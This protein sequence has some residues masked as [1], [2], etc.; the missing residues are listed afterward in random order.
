MISR[1][2]LIVTLLLA[3]V[4][5]VNLQ[6]AEFTGRFSMLGSTA[7]ATRGDIGYPN[8]DR[9]LTADQQSLRVMLDE[10]K[11]NSAW[12]V[13]VKMARQHLSNIPF[14][15]EHSSDLFRYNTLSTHWL[16]ESNSNNATRI[17]YEVD[18]AH[19]KHNLKNMTF[20]L[21][22]QP[23]DWGSARLWQP[24]NVFG[25][26]S[27]TD[28]DTDYKP[29]IDAARLDWF[30]SDFSAL[31]AVY[32]FSSSDN[33]AIE[34]NTNSALHYRSKIGMQSEYALLA[35]NIIDYQ[36]FGASFESAWAGLGW[37]V[38]AARYKETNT[39]KNSFFWV[40]GVD[41]QFKNGAIMTAEWYENDR[42]AS[43]VTSLINTNTQSDTL[44]KYGLQQQLVQRVFGVSINKDITPLVNAG[45]TLLASPLK[46]SEG[47]QNSSF[48]HQINL[49]YSV[50]NESDLLFSFQSAS[51]K[52]LNTVGKAQSEFGHISA[53]VAIRLRF[54]F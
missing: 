51:G 32:A 37:R 16:D 35:A 4:T 45:Y 54:Y 40:A 18:Q 38:E 36:I 8:Q 5:L 26:F 12:S 19:Y 3:P 24:L 42:G 52:G 6:S 48:L 49:T 27:P 53:S 50:S 11:N 41:Y 7:K 22:R 14:T 43:N 39:N 34:K 25:A 30:P 15:D 20:T 28:L 46:D 31:S 33:D 13:H 29:G 44:I 2:Q 17:G 1:A 47:K 9:T 21:G 10:R 23:I